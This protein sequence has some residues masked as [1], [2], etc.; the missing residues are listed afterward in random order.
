VPLS[1]Q[2]LIIAY[3]LGAK[4]K[5]P[6]TVHSSR[7]PA[8]MGKAG[9]HDPFSLLVKMV[10]CPAAGAALTGPARHCAQLPA[11]RCRT[12]ASPQ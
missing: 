8:A 9:H 3:K 7:N 1:G 12:V 4:G 10:V 6:N 11:Q 2:S 5:L